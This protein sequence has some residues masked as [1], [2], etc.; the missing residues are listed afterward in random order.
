MLRQMAAAASFLELPPVTTLALVRDDLADALSDAEQL[1]ATNRHDQQSKRSRSF[2]A[3]C[4]RTRR[5]PCGIAW[6]LSWSEMYRG[7]L[8]HAT[9]LLEHAE[10]S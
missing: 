10:T 6:H 9:E 1:V 7:E 8:D 3:D 4:V 2:G 5:W